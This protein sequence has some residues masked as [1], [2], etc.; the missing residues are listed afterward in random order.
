MVLLS[1]QP[2][3]AENGVCKPE[4]RIDQNPVYSAEHLR[5]HR[6]HGCTHDHSRFLLFD[7]PPEQFH[8]L[9]RS[10][11]KVRSDYLCPGQE[12]PQGPYASGLA[13]G[14]ESV[15]IEKLFAG[16]QLRPGIFIKFHRFHLF[17]QIYPE[18]GFV[19]QNSYFCVGHF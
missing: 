9:V 14:G 13:A 5:V 4:G 19:V 2:V 3:V 12:S 6:A 1:A 16:K 8:C 17:V 10:D 18:V 7:N 15:D 11:R